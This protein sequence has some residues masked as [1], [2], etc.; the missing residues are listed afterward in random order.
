ARA[1]RE[2]SRATAA[3]NDLRAAAP[4]IAAEARALASKEKF[5]EAIS[6]LDYATKLSPDAPD[7][8]LAKGDLLET[9]MRLPD[10]A[11]VYRAALKLKPDDARAKANAELCEQLAAAPKTPEGKLSRESLSRL[12]AQ[13]LKD[14]RST[15]EIMPVA[16]LVGDEKK[17]IVSYWLERL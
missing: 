15:A 16:R 2:A 12:N 8:L 11:A 9:Q 7:Y 3:L 14:Q 13:M 5:D 1:E 10:A 6:K 4:S 17:Y